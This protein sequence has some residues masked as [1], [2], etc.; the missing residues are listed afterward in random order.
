[1]SCTRKL[2]LKHNL[3]ISSA[4]INDLTQYIRKNHNTRRPSSRKKNI[5]CKIVISRLFFTT[6]E[7]N[8]GRR[9]FS[10]SLFFHYLWQ[11]HRVDA[12]FSFSS[13]TRNF[14]SWKKSR[15]SIHDKFIENLL[16]FSSFHSISFRRFSRKIKIRRFNEIYVHK[17][18]SSADTTH[19]VQS[20]REK[21]KFT[22]KFLWK[23]SGGKLEMRERESLNKNFPHCVIFSVSLFCTEL[24]RLLD[25]VCKHHNS[26]DIESLKWSQ[27]DSRL[28]SKEKSSHNG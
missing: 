6:T 9:S 28:S 27:L 17:Y 13:W 15:H 21:F 7:L 5:F 25:N 16:N 24:L 22:R 3:N 19:H 12:K 20:M 14:H 8:W 26:V 1:M 2:R 18:R 23:I 10:F 4:T 11:L